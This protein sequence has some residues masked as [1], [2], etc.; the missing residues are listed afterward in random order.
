MLLSHDAGPDVLLIGD[1]LALDFLNT[2]ASPHGKCIEWLRDGQ[3]LL[4]WLHRAGAIDAEIAVH[5]KIKDIARK[6]DRVTEDV[7]AL[8][9]WWRAF[10]LRH[11]GK[12]LGANAFKELE[13]INK[14]LAED[15]FYRQIIKASG[16][17]GQ[18]LGLQ[19]KR[20][21]NSPDQLVFPI[22]E[23][24]SD[25][26]CNLDFKLVRRCES[27]DCTVVFYDRTKSHARRWCSMAVCGNRAKA[28]AHRAR[29]RASAVQ[30]KT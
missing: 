27:D 7:R 30:D 14:L 15:K 1:H 9:E 20:E 22:A 6:L 16:K 19:K 12:P 5:F 23:A 2:I 11:A 25:L 29:L 26:V 21:W 18:A 28:A 17:E 24:I 8:R 13:P 4:N 10:V 3:D